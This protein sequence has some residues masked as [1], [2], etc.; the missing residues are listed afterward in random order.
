MIT[1]KEKQLDLSLIEKHIA[2]AKANPLKSG[3][4][5]QGYRK[6]TASPSLDKFLSKLSKGAIKTNTEYWDSLTIK[7]DFEYFQR[8]VFAICSVH[9][10]WESNVKGYNLLMSDLSWTISKNRLQEVIHKSGLGYA[11]TT[12]AITLSF[13]TQAKL[14]C[15]DVHILRFM[16][17]D[18]DGTPSGKFYLDMEQVWLKICRKHK[19]NPAVVREVYWDRVQNRMNPRY[20]SYCLER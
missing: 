11:K 15:L 1:K 12:F 6:P 18:R 4:N 20:W 9:T 19:V 14:V 10:T 16:G 13:P 5:K 2:I 8:W 7:N 3:T 17:Y